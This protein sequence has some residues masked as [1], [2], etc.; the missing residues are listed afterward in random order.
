MKRKIYDKLLEWKNSH[1][2]DYALLIDGARRVGKSYIVKEFAKNEYDSYIFIDF[3]ER[4]QAVLD[5]FNMYIHDLNLFF[6]ALS[7]YYKVDLIA[8]KTLI[9]FDEVQLFP[10]AREAIKRL[11]AD[12]RYSYIETGSLL[13]IKTNVENIIIP[14]EAM[15]IQLH[16]MDFE[17]FLMACGQDELI[18]VL[19][20]HYESGLPMGQTGHRV[21]M[22]LFRQY[23]V[24]GGMPKAVKLF[25]ETG[26]MSRV[27]TEKRSIIE[28]YRIDI[29]KYAG[30]TAAATRSLFEDISSQLSQH[31]K[32]FKPSKLKKD[33]RM[34]DFE[35]SILWLED[36]EIVSPC[37]KAAEP[38]IGLRLSRDRLTV[39][40]YMSDTG[41]LVSMSF[42]ENI[43][44]SPETYNSLINGKLEV[45]EGMIMENIVAQMLKANGHR[46]YFYSNSSRDDALSRMKIDFLIAKSK[47]TNRHNISPIEV[48]SGKNYTLSSLR[49]FRNK[50]S[51]QLASAYVIH[52]D[53]YKIDDGIIYLPIYMTMFL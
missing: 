35:D 34:R 26:N 37:Y 27:E 6:T 36:A 23:M 39:K 2:S 9:V 29:A 25:V 31:E 17:E 38:S 48:K 32:I 50:Y 8:H 41:L 13:S 28:L 22:K 24:V 20:K 33:A 43:L 4:D 46:L 5:I 42:D 15:H 53:D 44:V 12:G 18:T 11:V 49:K 7:K 52:M 16:P 14:S 21:A 47:T 40:N 1:S 19:K 10:M 51:E 30:K 45:N 3:A